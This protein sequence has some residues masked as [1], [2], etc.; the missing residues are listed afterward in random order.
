MR[1][2]AKAALFVCTRSLNKNTELRSFFRSSFLADAGIQRP[3]IMGKCLAAK[4]H[5]PSP[6]AGEGWVRGGP[7][8]S[9]ELKSALTD[10]LLYHIKRQK[11]SSDAELWR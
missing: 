2:A 11:I 6:L 5:S 1:R 10:I 9:I 7:Q 8:A 3:L 4:F